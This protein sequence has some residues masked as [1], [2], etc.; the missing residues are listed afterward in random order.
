M[1]SKVTLSVHFPTGVQ[2]WIVEGPDT[3]TAERYG[4]TRAFR[5]G[6]TVRTTWATTKT[7]IDSYAADTRLPT[8]R[9]QP[10]WE[11]FDVPYTLASDAV[12][13]DCEGE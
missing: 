9:S 1:T 4:R 7:D 11:K 6:G 5:S 3:P 8:M 12:I 2:F 10:M 13:A